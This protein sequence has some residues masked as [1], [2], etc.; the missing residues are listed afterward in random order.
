MLAWSETPNRDCSCCCH[1]L[2]GVPCLRPGPRTVL[3]FRNRNIAEA[4]LVAASV[5]AI[6]FFVA[7]RSRDS[8]HPTDDFAKVPRA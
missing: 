7:Y 1:P 6:S 2:I 8:C 3:Q 5:A 4:L